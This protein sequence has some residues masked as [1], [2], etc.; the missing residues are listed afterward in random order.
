ML[1]TNL[2]LLEKQH[3]L[4]TAEPSLQPFFSFQSVPVCLAVYHAFAISVFS[5]N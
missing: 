1:V 4:R 5:G 2:G 3:M